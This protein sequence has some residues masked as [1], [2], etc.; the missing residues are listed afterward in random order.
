MGV[1]PVVPW[2]VVMFHLGRG[3][4][5]S[6]RRGLLRIWVGGADTGGPDLANSVL[7][8][9]NNQQVAH[10]GAIGVDVCVVSTPIVG[11][12]LGVVVIG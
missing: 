3:S 11:Q 12:C 1:I 5:G 10:G 9:I 4:Q 7:T 2:R 6:H 8:R